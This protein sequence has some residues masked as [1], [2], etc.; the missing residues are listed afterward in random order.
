[1]M[2]ST[3][4]IVYVNPVMYIFNSKISLNLDNNL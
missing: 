3:G 4:G 1:M 2:H